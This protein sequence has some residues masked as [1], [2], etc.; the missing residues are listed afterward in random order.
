[1]RKHALACFWVIAFLAGCN[2]SP[3]QIEG[4]PAMKLT[5]TAFTEGSTIPKTY[6]GDGEDHSPPL[7]WSDVPEKTKCFALICDDPDAPLGTWVHWVLFNIPAD[8]REMQEGVSA[9]GT[10]AGGA[11]QGK[12]DFKKLGYGGPAPP[13]GKPHRYYFK[14]YAL[15]SMLDLKEG[16]SKKDVEQAIKGHILA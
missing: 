13:K 7:K 9:D 12:N 3:P 1:M 14:L 10:V 2:D 5:S 6:T 4:L 16:A 11:K 8:Q 15:D